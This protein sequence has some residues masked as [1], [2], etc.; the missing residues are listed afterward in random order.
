ME[1]FGVENLKILIA[2]PIEVGNIAVDI[3][4][5]NDKGWKKW[6]RLIYAIPEGFK[7]LKIDW[8]ALRSEYEDLSSEEREELKEMMK[9]KFH[10]ADE[11]LEETIEA[12]FAILINI[13]ASI[14]E[15][16]KLCHSIRS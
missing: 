15:A 14:R 7:L 2:F 16:M 13:E 1:K 6:L 5:D 12:S 3:L 10:L 4:A 11:K 8:S 9:E